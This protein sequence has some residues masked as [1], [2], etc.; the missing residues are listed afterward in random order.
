ML[1]VS[2]IGRTA[3]PRLTQL[4]NGRAAPPPVTRRIY[5]P[6]LRQEMEARVVQWS[7]MPSAAVL[8]PAIV[9][10]PTTTV[11]VAPTQQAELDQH[12]N[13]ILTTSEAT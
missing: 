11:Y 8:G 12:G 2:A 13:L 3:K 7:T 10:H 6:G 9:E 5:E 1:R 4:V